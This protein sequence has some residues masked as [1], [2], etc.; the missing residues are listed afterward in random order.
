MADI[1]EE[2]SKIGYE[3]RRKYFLW[4]NNLQTVKG[5]D[6]GSM[7]KEE[8]MKNAEVISEEG[9]RALEKWETSPEYIRL[10]Y[11]LYESNF[12]NDLLEVYDSI[13][14]SAMSGNATAVKTMLELQSEINK[15]LKQV[16]KDE[17]KPKLNLNI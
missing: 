5:L 7:S 13:K 9:I 8:F 17:D 11:I 4:K 15:R 6:Y 12:D 10:Q 14:K 16:N 1:W 2:L 3:R